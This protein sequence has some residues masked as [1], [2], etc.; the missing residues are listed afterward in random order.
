MISGGT[1]LNGLSAGGSRSGSAGSAG[2]SITFCIA[3]LPLLPLRCHSQTDAEDPWSRSRRRRSRMPWSD[4]ARAAARAPSDVRRRGRVSCRWRRLRRSQMWSRWPY[5]PP[6]SSSGLSAVLDHVGRAPFAGD[7]DVLA[8][9]PPEVVSEILRAAID[10]PPAEH[11][12]ALVIE[13]EDSARAV[14]V[15]ERPAR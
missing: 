13:Q 10:L 1:A 15:R 6:S 12:E 11:V 9:V 14:A 2:I 3:Q 4:R 8:E 7:R 5:L